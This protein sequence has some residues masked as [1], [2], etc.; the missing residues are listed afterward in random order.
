MPSPSLMQLEHFVLKKLVIETRKARGGVDVTTTEEEDQI[1]YD[2]KFDFRYGKHKDQL[3][4]GAEL[5]LTF[6]WSEES[7]EPYKRIVVVLDGF[8][9]F[10]DG[11]PEDRLK[12]YVPRLLGVNMIGLARGIV[13]Q[14][15]AFC[16]EGP[17]VIPI[18]DVTKDFPLEK[19]EDKTPDVKA[20]PHRKKK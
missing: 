3:R 7:N 1:D 13:S 10:P 15:T 8:F 2:C 12:H 16:L 19:K 11:T 20:A 5:G 4:F 6:T 18:L 17:F 9:R 14:A